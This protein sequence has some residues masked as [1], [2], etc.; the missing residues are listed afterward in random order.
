MLLGS[1]IEIDNNESDI[2]DHGNAAK[3]ETNLKSS[4]IDNANFALLLAIQ[5]I[6]AIKYQ[7]R[8]EFIDFEIK[9][10]LYNNDT[11]FP[12]PKLESWVAW[13][14]AIKKW[15]STLARISNISQNMQEDPSEIKEFFTACYLMI[16]IDAL[17]LNL[18][19]LSS[20]N[21]PGNLHFPIVEKSVFKLIADLIKNNN[22]T[23]WFKPELLEIYLRKESYDVW[24]RAI[25]N[26]MNSGGKKH[27]NPEKELL[28]VI[29][30]NNGKLF[31][32]CPQ[33]LKA[34]INIIRK[35]LENSNLFE[36]FEDI[37]K[38]R[39]VGSK[40]VEWLRQRANELINNQ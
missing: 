20:D 34:S 26:E 4:R 33:E 37:N 40:T 39:G 7:E 38:L 29:N 31:L 3:L 28:R 27:T 19:S 14:Y 5:S 18:E 9:P 36:S 16:M 21:F 32:D 22:I 11:G 13:E 8:I 24:I 6:N 12:H 15:N 1:W 10:W 25:K 35:H 23:L 17:M 2:I 30:S